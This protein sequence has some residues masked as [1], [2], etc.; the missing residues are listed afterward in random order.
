MR[1]LADR[2]ASDWQGLLALA[3]AFAAGLAG[4]LAMAGWVQ[5]PKKVEGQGDAIVELRTAQAKQA[6][7]VDSLSGDM[8]RVRCLVEA[9]ALHVDPIERCGL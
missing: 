2:I 4:A 5:L 8:R 7:R 6:V 3:G 9:G 1:R